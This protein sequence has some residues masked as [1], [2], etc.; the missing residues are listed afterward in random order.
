MKDVYAIP[1]NEHLANLQT[2]NAV[3][4]SAPK[5]PDLSQIYDRLM[6]NTEAIRD[7]KYQVQSIVDRIYGSR[8]VD[9]CAVEKSPE[10]NG[11]I[12]AIHLVINDQDNE[13]AGLRSQIHRLQEL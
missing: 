5:Q 10:P 1:V 8:P 13:I 4:L 11:A 12:E 7:L 3:G 2:K 9:A 6:I